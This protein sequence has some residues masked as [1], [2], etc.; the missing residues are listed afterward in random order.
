MPGSIAA[1]EVAVAAGELLIGAH[2]SVADAADA[3]VV[4]QRAEFRRL[5]DEIAGE[6]GGLFA[7]VLHRLAIR[8]DSLKLV[9]DPIDAVVEQPREMQVAELFE[10]LF[11]LRGE[12]YHR[13]HS[14]VPPA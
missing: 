4:H 11:L 1:I 13:I 2:Q 5:T 3:R 14:R 10:K 8:P 6:P 9:D 12:F 7:G